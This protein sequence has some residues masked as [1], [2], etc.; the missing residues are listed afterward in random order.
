MPGDPIT[1][2]S[3][4]DRVATAPSNAARRRAS[5]SSRPTST[6][7]AAAPWPRLR[8]E[9]HE[10]ERRDRL[11]LALQVQRRHRL[12][13]HVAAHEPLRLLA[14]QHLAVAG[15]LLEPRRDVDRV[16]D[17]VAVLATDDDL[18]GVDAGAQMQLHAPVA[19]QLLVQHDQA[20]DERVGGA[21]AAQR[22]VLAHDRRPERRHHAVAGELD[23]L[24]LVAPRSPRAPC[25]RSASSR[26]GPTRCR[27]S[28]AGSWTRR[29]PRTGSSPSCAAHRRSACSAACAVAAPQASQKRAPATSSVP[30]A[31]QR[32]ANGDPHS[33]QNRAPSRFC[34]PHAEQTA[35]AAP[36]LLVFTRSDHR[37]RAR[38][39]STARSLEASRVPG[40]ALRAHGPVTHRSRR[41][42]TAIPHR[43]VMS[44]AQTSRAPYATSRSFCASASDCSFFSDWFSIWRMR[45]RVTL[46]VLPT[47]SSV[48]GCSPPRP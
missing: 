9:R 29:G 20:G 32:S 5:S 42:W 36:S 33:T 26:A 10:P 30:Q 8:A 18:A 3:A 4:H 7:S 31:A 13:L 35:G 21:H 28:P 41:E 2:T 34:E 47:S 25:R 6:V 23:D 39:R 27:A 46:K 12:E 40:S 14:D 45:S 1:V 24:P 48:R 44:P 38:S 16:A 37:A 17:Q 22:V 43:P 11:R 15:R 19:L